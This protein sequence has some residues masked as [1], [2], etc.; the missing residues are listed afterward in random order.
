MVDATQALTELLPHAVLTNADTAAGLSV[1]GTEV[2]VRTWFAAKI[3][4]Y[5][6]TVEEL[7]ND[8]GISYTVETR[9]SIGTSVGEDWIPD[10]TWTGNTVVPQGILL[11]G[12]GEAI[13]QTTI[14][15][16]E[17]P[18]TNFDFGSTSYI[19]DSSV[20]A[21]GEWSK[22][23]H[24]SSTVV[25]ITDGLLTAKDD[26]DL[27]WNQAAVFSGTLALTGVS[28]LR[29]RAQGADTTGADV[30]YKA[31]MVELTDIE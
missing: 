11:N 29:M 8:P 9:W 24:R 14:A 28:W 30:H 19:E 16:A 5:H 3:Y 4:V 31:H 12:G 10:W 23:A 26:S 13:G 2:D 22:V 6:A 27:I 25:T 18:V 17:T 7:A 21:D 15:V 1:I 20:V